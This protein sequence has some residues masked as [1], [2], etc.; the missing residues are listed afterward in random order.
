M[1]FAL[2]V[3]S[4]LSDALERESILDAQRL[5]GQLTATIE[6]QRNETL[7]LHGRITHLEALVKKQKAELKEKGM[8]FIEV[9]KQAFSEKSS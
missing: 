1:T 4:D 7:R 5:C 6:A 8:E 9:D 3:L 2:E